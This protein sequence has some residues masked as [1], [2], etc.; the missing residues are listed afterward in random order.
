MSV[1]HKSKRNAAGNSEKVVQPWLIARVS[2]SYWS[3]GKTGT[4]KV[5]PGPHYD[6]DATMA[7]SEPH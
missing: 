2:N 5:T 4:Y 7:V 3:E 1:I 6:A